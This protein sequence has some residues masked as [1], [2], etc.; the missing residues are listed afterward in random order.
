MV[1]VGVK[2]ERMA[3]QMVLVVKKLPAKAGDVKR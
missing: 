3:S 2:R 1:M